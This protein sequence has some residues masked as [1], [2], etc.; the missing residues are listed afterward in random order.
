MVLFAAFAS[1]VVLCARFSPHSHLHGRPIRTPYRLA[2]TFSG[3]IPTSGTAQDTNLTPVAPLHVDKGPP[4]GP[5]PEGMT[6]IPPGRFAMGSAQGQE[7]ARPVHTVELSGFWMDTTPVTNAEFARFVAATHYITVAER[8]PSATELPNVPTDKRIA[9]ALVFH[10]PST[11]VPLNDVS[12]WWQYV[13]GACWSHP[14]GPGSDLQGRADHPVVQ[15]CYDDAVAYARWA[16]KRLPTEAEWEYAARGGLS[17]MPYVWGKEQR[18]GGKYMANTWQGHF[19]NV[20]SKADGYARTSPV[21]AFPA[22]GFGLYDMAGNVWE[23]CS[24]WY[25]PDYYANSP[26]IDPQGPS[27]SFDP[28]EPDQPKRV[29]RGGSFLC[30]DQYCSGYRPDRRGRGAVDTGADNIGFRCVMSPQNSK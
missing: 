5:T 6:W 20:N 29:Q 26:R 11:A 27:D 28:D 15:V 9:G 24:D 7:D 17:Q 13:P 3:R 25:R 21:R 22:N 1:V 16:G 18:P 12:R 23:W 2:S 19:P 30:S 4:A 8:T 10:S 14:E